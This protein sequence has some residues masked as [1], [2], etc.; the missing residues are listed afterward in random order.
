MVVTEETKLPVWEIMN[1]MRAA[2]EEVREERGVSE[3]VTELVANTFEKYIF[4]E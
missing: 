4:G 1:A 3:E 2:L